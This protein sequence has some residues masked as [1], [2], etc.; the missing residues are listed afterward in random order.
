M[1][2]ADYAAAEEVKDRG[3]W[4]LRRSVVIGVDAAR[5]SGV[6]GG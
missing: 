4:P 3:S 6:D 1:P 5:A 2:V